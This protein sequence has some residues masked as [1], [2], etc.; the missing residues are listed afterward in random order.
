M[1]NEL[2]VCDLPGFGHNLMEKCTRLNVSTC[3]DVRSVSFSLLKKELGERTAQSLLEFSQGI[4][5]RVLE[6]KLRQSVGGDVNW[7]IRFTEE[8]QVA[9]FLREFSE[10]IFQRL[11]A[12][13]LA[14]SHLTVNVKKKLYQGEPGKFLGCGHC[15]DFSKSTQTALPIRSAAQLFEQVHLLYREIGVPFPEVRGVGIHLKRLIRNGLGLSNSSSLSPEAEGL[16]SQAISRQQTIAS[17]FSQVAS[18]PLLSEKPQT[19]IGAPPATSRSNSI[20]AFFQTTSIKEV[21]PANPRETTDAS[22]E[23]WSRSSFPAIPASSS[24]LVATAVICSDTCDSIDLTRDDADQPQG[25]ATSPLPTSK[26][27][28]KPRSIDQFF[29]SDNLQRSPFPASPPVLPLAPTARPREKKRLLLS[30][31]FEP[32]K[33]TDRRTGEHAEDELLLE[34][35]GIDLDVFAALPSDIRREQLAVLRANKRTK[36]S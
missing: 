6:N 11:A 15:Q 35:S 16:P 8:G 10:D 12:N 31:F 3:K 9:V 13:D 7:G 33:L 17:L 34:E 4:D 19:S 30:T 32:T 20:A 25:E 2:S 24:D 26:R 21:S 18:R 28:E 29:R 5:N 23:D 1:L 14:A 27:P 36:K 22:D